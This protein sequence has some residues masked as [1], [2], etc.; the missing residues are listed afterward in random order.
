[1]RVRAEFGF[2]IMVTPYSQ[3]F[4]VQA[5]INVMVGERYKE[6]TDEVLLYTLGFW[7]EEEARCIDDD[8]KDRLLSSPRAKELAQMDRSTLSVEEFRRKFGGD[9]VSDDDKLLNYF[10][11]AEAVGAM[12]TAGARSSFEPS[13]TSSLIALIEEIGRRNGPLQFYIK[14]KGVNL[15]A[16]RRAK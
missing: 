1:S 9:S 13:Q 11:G 3:F 12:R 2:P 4:G 5:A 14:R 16:E 7:G 10:A 6:V 15:R 8:L